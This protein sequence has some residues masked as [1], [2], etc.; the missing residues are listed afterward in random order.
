LAFFKSFEAFASD[1]GE[2]NEYVI[3]AFNFD[4]AETFLSVEPFNST[5][6]HVYYL[7]KCIN[8]R[9]FRIE[10]KNSHIEKGP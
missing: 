2:V 9:L 1:C 6:L 8:M 10:T 7:Q 4:E 5:L 3:A